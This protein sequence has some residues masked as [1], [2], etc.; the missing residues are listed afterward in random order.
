MDQ[1]VEAI[2]TAR[3]DTKEINR[4]GKNHELFLIARISTAGGEWL[5]PP[6]VVGHQ[7]NQLL[8]TNMEIQFTMW[9][10]A[11]PGDYKLWVILY[12]RTTGKQN[13]ASHRIHV[14]GLRGDPLPDLYNKMP[15]AEIADVNDP[16]N[17]ANNSLAGNLYLPV[18]RSEERR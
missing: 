3:I 14:R 13:V 1:R 12:D 2:Y 6:N 9:V 17:D 11:Q 8:P 18:H 5:T 16:S 7:I 10:I 15:P 4:T